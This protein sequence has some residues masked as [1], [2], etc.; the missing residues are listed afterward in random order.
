MP[1]T[2]TPKPETERKTQNR[3]KGDI[4]I[5]NVQVEAEPV[6]QTRVN[7]DEYEN[8]LRPHVDRFRET[9][10][11]Q[12]F[13]FNV[14]A[15]SEDYL[16]SKLRQAAVAMR[17]PVSLRITTIARGSEEAAKRGYVLRDPEGDFPGENRLL[18]TVNPPRRDRKAEAAGAQVTASV[19]GE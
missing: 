15:G 8:L 2:A 17:A 3:Y 19:P 6:R 11:P 7:L 14:I 18:V 9:S 1:R 4:S 13:S 5:T 10:K 12:H 16:A